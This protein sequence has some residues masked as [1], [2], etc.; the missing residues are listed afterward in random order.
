MDI[1]VDQAH[2]L[3]KFGDYPIIIRVGISVSVRSREHISMHNFFNGLAIDLKLQQNVRAYQA[4]ILTKIDVYTI[5]TQEVTTITDLSQLF[6]RNPT[7]AGVDSQRC[8]H[9][10]RILSLILE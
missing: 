2:I 7:R 1:Y 10:N 4:H 6:S 8:T 5:I 9:V 3:A